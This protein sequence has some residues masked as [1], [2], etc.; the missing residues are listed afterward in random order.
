MSEWNIFWKVL[1]ANALPGII[2]GGILA[3]ARGLGEFGAS[4]MIA[5]NIAGRTRTL[6]MAVYSD[7]AAGN[8]AN[9]VDYVMIIVIIAFIAIFIMDF[10]SIR[11]ERQ[12]R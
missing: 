2:S 9:A 11:N 12:W 3:Y 7:V 8:M 5:G 4:L 10:I 6:P 1:F